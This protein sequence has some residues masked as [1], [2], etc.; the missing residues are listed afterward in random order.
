MKVWGP[1][2]WLGGLG[3]LDP[4]GVIQLAF[5]RPV[6][7]S[8][9][10]VPTP[11]QRATFHPAPALRLTFQRHRRQ[12]ALTALAIALGVYV[13]AQWQSQATNVAPAAETA[14]SRPS[15]SQDTINRLEAEQAQLKSEIA[16]L[17]TKTAAQEKDLANSQSTMA[18]LNAELSQQR[19]IAGTTALQ[20]NG[21]EVLLDDNTQRV[22]LPSD[23]PDDYIV[24]E[25]QIR[26]IV[27]LLWSS[28]AV[29]ISV[30][31]ERFVNSTS[32]YCVG[33]TILIN[34]TRTSPPYHIVAIGDTGQLQA[35]L[36][37]GNA[38]RDL[39]NRVQVY[40]LVLKVEQ[41]GKF[42][43]P[44]FNGG[45]AMKNTSTVAEPSP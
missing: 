17:R 8:S 27:N 34:D 32:V 30:N 2:T 13:A 14:V 9:P 37:D 36:S 4:G 38:L 23:N 1:R 3:I 43:L 18:T 15:L 40:G 25:Y 10:S 22:L 21:V 6:L 39:K 28:G 19:A 35:A 20:G 29:G 44:A 31:G 33:S 45:I 42:T 12:I 41:T 26:D 5:G 24:H 11:A 16:V 7:A